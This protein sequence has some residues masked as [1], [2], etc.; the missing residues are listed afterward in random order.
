MR[1]GPPAKL[2][3]RFLVDA[4]T[5]IPRVTTISWA[6]VAA[7]NYGRPQQAGLGYRLQVE[8]DS[9]GYSLITEPAMTRVG[10]PRLT[11][12]RRRLGRRVQELLPVSAPVEK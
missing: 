10:R 2:G 8:V 12:E 3:S 6:I 7:G 11:A 5:G 9:G 1:L 4:A